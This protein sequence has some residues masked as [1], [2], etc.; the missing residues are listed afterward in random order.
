MIVWAAMKTERTSA[1][2]PS[3]PEMERAFAARNPDYD[4]L[5]FVAVQSTGIF[6]RPSCPSRPNPENVEFL[7][8]VKDCLIA[9]YRPCKRC[10]PTEVDG[11]P[12]E[13]VADLMK[14]VSEA[15][16]GRWQ[17]EDLRALGV[18]PER[19]RRWFKEHHGM[20]FA[21][22]CRAHRLAGAFQ[23]L[24]AGAAPDAA[25]FDAGFESPSGFRDA[26]LRTFGTSPGRARTGRE[27]VVV[28]RIHSPIG[29]FLGGT[30]DDGICLLE[31]ADRR[32]L[33][34][35]VGELRDRYGS[36]LVPGD[37]PRL[38]QLQVEL[39]AYFAGA[40]RAFSVPLA[41]CGT[42]FQIQVWE[43]LRRIPYGETLSYEQLAFRVGR[44]TGQRAVAQANGLNRI[45]ILIPCHRVIGKDGGLTGY[46]GGLWRKRLLLELERSGRLPGVPA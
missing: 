1:L 8:S 25:G 17:A 36:A 33:E 13:W 24:R 41:P 32:G 14:R 12:P 34:H 20:T 44:A 7:P 21:A 29:P 15:P 42:P 26:F 6:C 39:A 2:L 11:R 30:R 16:D 3:R 18:T 46:G 23:S 35:Q 40:R 31:Y 45:A 10:R 28:G 4:G 22:W 38:A 37:H 9:G 43:E 5:F 19:A 27:P